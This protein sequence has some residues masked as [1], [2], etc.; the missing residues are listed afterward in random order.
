MH[1]LGSF[2]LQDISFKLDLPQVDLM[3]FRVEYMVEYVR[4]RS[5]R[6][7]DE[8]RRVLNKQD[9]GLFRKSTFKSPS[10][11]FLREKYDTLVSLLWAFRL[12][13]F[14]IVTPSRA[15]TRTVCKYSTCGFLSRKSYLPSCG[16]LRKRPSFTSRNLYAGLERLLQLQYLIELMFRRELDVWFIPPLI[17]LAPQDSNVAIYPQLC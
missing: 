2:L 1:C 13:A 14:Y 4:P 7:S 17:V 16:F 5:G 3:N 8:V 10:I 9:E 12:F 15:V 11:C 6:A